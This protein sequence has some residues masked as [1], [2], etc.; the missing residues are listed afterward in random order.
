MGT[1]YYA[2][3][4]DSDERK[5]MMVQCIMK[6][7]YDELDD[8]IPRKIHIG[9]SSAGWKYVFNHNDWKY[10]KK[11]RKSIASFLRECDIVDEYKRKVT[12]EEFWS[13]VDTKN[14]AGQKGDN[15]YKI[16]YDGLIFSDSTNFF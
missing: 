3:P 12:P 1:N 2:T 11:N 14:A 8:L 9:K 15:E 16:K 13:M 4:R 5:V 6:H 7:N 10:F